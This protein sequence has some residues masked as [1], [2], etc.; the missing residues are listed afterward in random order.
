METRPSLE[1]LLFNTSEGGTLCRILS[2]LPG[3][4]IF[5]TKPEFLTIRILFTCSRLPILTLVG[6][7]TSVGYLEIVMSRQPKEPTWPFLCI[8]ACLFVLSAAAPRAWE[9]TIRTRDA[10]PSSAGAVTEAE[11]PDATT[12]EVANAR[13]E[14]GM[15]TGA[16]AEIAASPT[17]PLAAP[18]PT[19]GSSVES[20]EG[21][22][23]I[24]P[25]PRIA[26]RVIDPNQVRFDL[27][28]AKP[29]VESLELLP[30]HAADQFATEEPDAFVVENLELDAAVPA[31]PIAAEAIDADS[32]GDTEE[33]DSDAGG[34]ISSSSSEACSMSIVP[35]VSALSEERVAD[36]AAERGEVADHLSPSSPWT[37]PVSIYE[38]LEPLNWECETGEWARE[39]ADAIR[40]AAADLVAASPA[41]KESVR[42]LSILG[43]DG[44]AIAKPME[45]TPQFEQMRRVLTTLHRRVSVWKDLVKAMPNAESPLAPIDWQAVRHSIEKLQDLTA[46]AENGEAWDSFLELATLA[47]IAAREPE[48]LKEEERT[49]ACYV[50][51]NL[52][53]D[54]VSEEQREFLESD[55]L[56]D[57]RAALRMIVT[58]PIDTSEWIS[59]LEAFER[60]NSPKAGELLAIERL[61]LSVSSQPEQVEL[62]RKVEEAYCGPN[63]RI[64]VTGY[65]LNRMLP[66]REPEYQW[67]RDTVLGHPVQGRSRTSAEVGLALIPDS[68]RMRAALTVDG[69]VSASTSSTA[70]PATFVNDSE[71]E[72]SAVKEFELTPMGIRFQ[73]AEVTVDNRTRLRE[74][75]TEFDAI[76]LVG[77]FVHS[78]ARS[79]HDASRPAIRREMNRKIQSQAE[80]QIDEEIDARL[81]ELNNR[82]KQRLLDPLA[83]MSLRPEVADAQTSEARMSMQLELAGAGQLGSNTPRPWAPSDSVLSFQMHQSA[84]NN[85]LRGLELDG[86]T[87]TIKELRER[88]AERFN[89]PELL[90][91]TNEH[92]DVSI[93]FASTD[94]ARIDFEE[95]RVA[96]SLGVERLQAGKRHWSDFR[97]RAYYSP[98]TSR[99]SASLARDGVV[100]LIGR[101]RVGS[102]IT[103]RS[104]FS[105]V[106]A[107]GRELPIVPEQMAADPR[108]QGLEV[109]QVVVDDGWFALAVGPERIRPAMAKSPASAMLK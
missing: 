7:D 1:G 11:M 56:S 72:Y 90:E 60:T 46:E 43:R 101:M 58:E 25:S 84:L 51:L 23:L 32:A 92:D 71:S 76:P 28:D 62:A 16:G 21:L 80:R 18:M 8:L 39:L 67:V 65:L 31:K 87:L 37:I 94:A 12:E 81:G 14:D 77:S 91:Q 68:R 27:T 100:E 22:I 5:C 29:E 24:A 75:R 69:L 19:V 36:L 48:Q 82:L 3:S 52:Q 44:V 35:G 105:K 104:I 41:A 89:R 70:G 78:V 50:L 54:D 64:A 61:K 59:L 98:Q 15:P 86:A 99:R 63:V 42:N 74:I 103:L 6:L 47:E 106:F 2:I 20:V 4:P 45:G 13:H 79:Q 17:I 53:V 57:Y 38:Q 83:A 102:Q 66:D 96:I 88:I 26:R 30:P 97:V 10:C 95:G 40:R 108:L 73:P 107:K 109:T 33:P 9:K 93:T 85:V 55:E 49:L 34:E